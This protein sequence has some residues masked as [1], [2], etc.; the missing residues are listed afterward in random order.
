M[1]KFPLGNS[2]N[3]TFIFCRVPYLNL[4]T[5]SILPATTLSPTTSKGDKSSK[6]MIDLS[7]GEITKIGE[8]LVVINITRCVVIIVFCG[9]CSH[10]HSQSNIHTADSLYSNSK[11]CTQSFPPVSIFVANA[12]I[13]KSR[14]FYRM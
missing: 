9:H 11:M 6:K 13:H 4:L 10:H 1:Q 5:K 12:V 8:N 7:F 3:G 2:I 14:P